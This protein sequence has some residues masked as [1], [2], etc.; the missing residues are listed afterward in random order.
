[1][2]RFD[3]FNNKYN[4]A[5]DA[6][7]RKVFLKSSNLVNGKYFGQLLKENI[8]NYEKNGFIY[9]ELRIGAGAGK[10]DWEKKAKWP[11]D[12]GLYSD[13]VRFGVQVART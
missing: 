4:V 11:R 1:M 10:A 12:M 3:L 8:A 13:H 7:L 6:G 5:G 2:N 9:S